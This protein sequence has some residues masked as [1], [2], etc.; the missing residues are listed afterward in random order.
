MILLNSHSQEVIQLSQDATALLV[1]LFTISSWEEILRVAKQIWQDT[2]SDQIHKQMQ[3]LVLQLTE[4][5]WITLRKL[6]TTGAACNE[7]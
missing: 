1:L 2:A 5:G 7:V 4:G 6:L 3:T